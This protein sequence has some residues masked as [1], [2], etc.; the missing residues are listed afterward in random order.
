VVPKDKIFQISENRSPL[1]IRK[2]VSIEILNNFIYKMFL[3][4]TNKMS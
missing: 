1:S 2:R 4:R 3:Q